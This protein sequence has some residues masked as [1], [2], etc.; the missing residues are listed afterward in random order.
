MNLYVLA[1][2]SGNRIFLARK[3]RRRIKT[4]V[5]AGMTTKVKLRC[6]MQKVQS[7]E[8]EGGGSFVETDAVSRQCGFEN[9]L[10]VAC[11]VNRGLL[12]SPMW[13]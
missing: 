2:N 10:M 4:N 7:E 12:Q 3:E 11:T 1:K 13:T 5:S 8:S 9:T 6:N